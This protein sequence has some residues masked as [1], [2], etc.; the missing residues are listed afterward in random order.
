MKSTG[1]MVVV[2]AVVVIVLGS[3][4]R[5]VIAAMQRERDLVSLT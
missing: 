2:A 4:H 5:F 3:A 1:S